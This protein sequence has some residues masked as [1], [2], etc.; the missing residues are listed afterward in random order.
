MAM[1][2]MQHGILTPNRK[3]PNAPARVVNARSR[4]KVSN[5]RIRLDKLIKSAHPRICI[6]RRLGGI[7]DVL[8]TTPLLK[9]IKTVLP[10]CHLT[11]ATDLEYSQ[12][13]LGDII[14]HNP[15]VDELIS[16]HET[17]DALFDYAVDITAT[18][19]DKE[20]PGTIP[21]NRIDMFADAVGVDISADPVPIYM[22]EESEREQANEFIKKHVK[23]KKT[24][25]AIQTRSNDARRTWPQDH[26]GELLDL[27]A[28]EEDLHILV[29][30]WGHTVERWERHKAPNVQVVANMPLI[31]VAA[32]L[33]QCEVVVCPDS[34]ILHLAGALQK[35]T[36]AIFGPIPPE[37]RCNHYANTT[38]LTKK[39]PC[40]PC[41]Y[42][43][44]CTKESGHKFACLTGISPQEVKMSI[45]DKI[46]SKHIVSNNIIY[47]KDL[48]DKNQD[49]IILVRRTTPGIG[50]ILMITPAIAALKEKYP[51]KRIE[52]ACQ[53]Y[54]WPALKNNPDI[55]KVIDCAGNINHKRYYAII[56]LSS[57]CARYES[58]RVASGKEVQKSRAEIFAEASGVRENLTNLKP[59]YTVTLDEKTWAED[60]LKK[61][62]TSNKPKVAIGLRSAEMYRNWPEK[63][64]TDLFN[65]LQ[66]HFEIV[67]ID[68]SREHIF[69]NVID[70]CGFPLR[71]SIAIL[72]QCDGLITVDTSLLHFGA[73]L[74]KPTVAIF[75][76]IDYKP[77]CKGYDKVTVMKADIDCIPCWRNSK[78]PCKSTGVIRGYSKCMLSIGPK[79]V[80]KVTIN[81]FLGQNK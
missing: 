20:K 66:P 23:G 18:G 43:P 70:A 33:D 44:R 16:F 65:T 10:S 11:Y 12:K 79:H 6:K 3:M 31:E 2:N 60:F 28:K 42:T 80:A 76:P 38:V 7:G 15:Y 55:Y 37:S 45:R 14:R 32:L 73:A 62:V 46:T 19:L 39:L 48:T 69:E 13:A 49:P 34:G 35:K 22:I 5:T 21:P 72:E 63:Y 30:D 36:V 57:P 1:N 4:R 74:D 51:D 47:G 53:K 78:I 26:V 8:M 40:F 17:R 9:A 29:F 25:I 68:H 64:F 27:L 24:L 59:R 58:A 71:K 54:L 56:D 77:R 67:L 41:W 50:D 75:G 81:K 61:T 52:V